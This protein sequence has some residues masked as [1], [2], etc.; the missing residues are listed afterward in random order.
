[1]IAYRITMDISING[2]DRANEF[3]ALLRQ[4]VFDGDDKVFRDRD[5]NI[6]GTTAPPVKEGVEWNHGTVTVIE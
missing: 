2:G 1:M 4:F 5:L 3:L 6:I